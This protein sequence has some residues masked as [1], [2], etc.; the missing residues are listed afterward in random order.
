[1]N[2]TTEKRITFPLTDAPP[3]SFLPSEWP[4]LADGVWSDHD[5]KVK[6]QANREWDI[7]IRVRQHADGRTLVLGRYEYNTCWESERG[8][9]HRV[10]LLLDAEADL[11]YAIRTIGHQ[12]IGRL[13]THKDDAPRVRE[14]V[15]ECIADLPA[16]EI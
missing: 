16:Q 9:L 7:L 14:C 13:D 12:L 2:D 1:M 8:A 11:L 10:G 15:A 3:V 4:I 5:G 6:Y